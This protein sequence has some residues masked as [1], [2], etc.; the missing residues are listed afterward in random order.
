MSISDGGAWGTANL[1]NT[2]SNALSNGS[3]N[4]FTQGVLDE[5]K[6]ELNN[7]AKQGTS[8]STPDCFSGGAWNGKTIG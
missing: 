7:L 6:S 5:I 1:M 4:G 2:I 8:A 3:N